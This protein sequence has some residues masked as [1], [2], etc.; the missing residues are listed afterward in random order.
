MTTNLHRIFVYGS[1][2]RGLGNH[3]QLA[4]ATFDGTATTRP[5]FRLYDLGAF[6]GMV[7]VGNGLV[8]GEVYLVDHEL[9]ERLDWFESHPRWYRRTPIHLNDGSSAEAY[10]LELRHVED[11]PEVSSGDWA[12]H[13]AQR[14]AAVAASSTR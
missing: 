14:G 9:L 1:L 7:A 6:P 11:R 2:R 10:L 5:G 13:W 3:G 8:V 12:A 4:G